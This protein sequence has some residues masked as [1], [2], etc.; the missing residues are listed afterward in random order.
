[1]PY[2]LRQGRYHFPVSGCSCVVVDVVVDPRIWERV[3][4]RRLVLPMMNATALVVVVVDSTL[5]A[6]IGRHRVGPHT[7]KQVP[8]QEAGTVAVVCSSKLVA[9]CCSCLVLYL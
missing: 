8:K 3:G 4:V 6:H 5:V 9:D 1:M 2:N 7:P